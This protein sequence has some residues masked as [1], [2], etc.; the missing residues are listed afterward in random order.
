MKPFSLDDLAAIIAQRADSTAE[1][2]YTKS[3]L[4]AGPPRAAQKFGEEAVELIIAAIEGERREVLAEAA[5]VVYHLLVLLAASG[6]TLAELLDELG[7]RS[8][9]S[10]HAEKASRRSVADAST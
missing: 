10:G 7:R 6:V 4:E 8:T 1:A 5:D 3:L 9:R 2:S